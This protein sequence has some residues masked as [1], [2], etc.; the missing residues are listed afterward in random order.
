VDWR[1]HTRRLLNRPDELTR[2]RLAVLRLVDPVEW[3]MRKDE[4]LARPARRGPSPGKRGWVAYAPLRHDGQADF[5]TPH[6]PPRSRDD[7]HAEWERG[8]SR[9]SERFG[10]YFVSRAREVVAGATVTVRTDAGTVRARLVRFRNGAVLEC[11]VVTPG[12]TGHGMMR[13]DHRTLRD[14]VPVVAGY[15]VDEVARLGPNAEPLT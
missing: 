11:D 14:P 15:L 5:G 3:Y 9:L 4:E 10:E 8:R 13:F 6:S 12:G 1:D 2:W 7:D